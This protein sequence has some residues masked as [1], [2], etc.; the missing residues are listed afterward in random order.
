MKISPNRSLCLV[1]TTQE[2]CGLLVPPLPMGPT[3][4]SKKQG[5]PCGGSRTDKAQ[6]PAA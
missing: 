2:K 6:S 5:L 4:Y 3:G 1:P